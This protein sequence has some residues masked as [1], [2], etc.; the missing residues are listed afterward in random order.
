MSAQ[1]PYSN[2]DKSETKKSNK[3]IIGDYVCNK[4]SKTHCHHNSTYGWATSSFATAS[5]IP[6]I[7]AFLPQH[8]STLILIYVV[9]AFWWK[10]Y[11]SLTTA[12]RLMTKSSI[13]ADAEKGS[14]ILWNCF[15]RCTEVLQRT[16]SQK[17]SKGGV[18]SMRTPPFNSIKTYFVFAKIPLTTCGRTTLSVVWALK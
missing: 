18:F 6:H 8:F 16:I 12:I 4:N 7:I 5:P 15:R 17:T 1:K 10:K 13:W 9:L 11:S 14:Y 3:Q 2:N